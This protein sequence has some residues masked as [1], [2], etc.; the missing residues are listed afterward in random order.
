MEGDCK[1]DC[2]FHHK[3]V[4]GMGPVANRHQLSAW[5]LNPTKSWATVSCFC[6]RT[7]PPSFPSY[8]AIRIGHTHDGI[9]ADRGWQLIERYCNRY[10][11]TL[12]DCIQT[13]ILDPVGWYIGG[14]AKDW[15]LLVL[16]DRED[17][18]PTKVLCVIPRSD[19]CGCRHFRD[20]TMDD[21]LSGGG[22]VYYSK[23]W[24]LPP[25]NRCPEQGEREI[26]SHG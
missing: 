17:P 7:A 26:H 10:T 22:M 12:G 9:R 23:L 13:T 6:K 19:G 16:L 14:S 20:V 3:T 1:C 18:M 25:E 24:R 11:Y 8:F 2:L 15:I 5:S 21:G 4:C